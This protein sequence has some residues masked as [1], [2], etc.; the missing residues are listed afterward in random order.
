MPVKLMIDCDPGIG[1]ALA[2]AAALFDPDIDLLALTAVAGCVPGGGATRNIQAVVENL[3]PPKWPRIGSTEGSPAW[4][5][6]EVGSMEID[7]ADLNGAS[8][9]GD[10]EFRVADLHHRHE[11][12]KLMIDIARQEPNEVVLL[13]LGPLTNLHVACERFPDFLNLLKGVVCLGGAVSC[14]GDVTAA[15][16]F[17]IHADAEAARAVLTTPATKTLIP[18]DISRRL[19]LTFEQYD[20]FRASTTEQLAEFLERLLPFAF[21]AHHQFLGLEGVALNE[22]VA[23]AAVMHPRLFECTPMAIDVETSGEL[24]RG[25]TVFD[26]RGIPHWQTNIDVATDVDTQGILDYFA[27]VLRKK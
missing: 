25:T 5:H 15:A 11:S 14:G 9:L 1:D 7:L 18:L 3:D 21:R 17:N 6:T 26:K 24:T 22:L 19:V 12:A 2:I 10:W 20:R 4:S 27:R 23:L 8:G 16:E 13:T